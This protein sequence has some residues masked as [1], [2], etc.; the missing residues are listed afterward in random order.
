MNKPL[1]SVCDNFI[2]FINVKYKILI[3]DIQYIRKQ[4]PVR[5][6]RTSRDT[7]AGKTRTTTITAD[8]YVVAA[9]H[10]S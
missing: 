10:R 2:L 8:G 5:M 9:S 7:L 4:L 3:I 1:K 6:K